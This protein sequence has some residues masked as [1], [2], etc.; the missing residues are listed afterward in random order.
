MRL[1]ARSEGVNLHRGDMLAFSHRQ[2]FLAPF[3]R[4]AFRK[5]ALVPRALATHTPGVGT[6]LFTG[7]GARV[8]TCPRREKLCFAWSCS[9]SISSRRSQSPLRKPKGAAALTPLVSM[10]PRLRRPQRTEVAARTPWDSSRKRSRSYCGSALCRY[11]MVRGDDQ[12]R[13]PHRDRCAPRGA[14]TIQRPEGSP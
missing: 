13:L 11:T 9:S 6:A 2:M 8:V 7:N 10:H 1:S 4:H 5:L 3:P 14:G 12:D